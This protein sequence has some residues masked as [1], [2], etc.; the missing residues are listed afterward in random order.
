M[1]IKEIIFYKIAIA[2]VKTTAHNLTKFS[3]ISVLI[4]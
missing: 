1:L 2:V 3:P 4:E